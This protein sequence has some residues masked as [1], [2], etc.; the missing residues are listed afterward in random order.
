MALNDEHDASFS[1]ACCSVSA[2][3]IWNGPV[4]KTYEFSV[5]IFFSVS[6]FGLYFR[7]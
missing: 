5:F 6:I 4:K 2:C 3:E 1:L 7:T